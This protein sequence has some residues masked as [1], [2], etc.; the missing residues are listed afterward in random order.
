MKPTHVLSILALTF[1]LAEATPCGGQPSNLTTL[2]DPLGG[3]GYADGTGSAARFSL[4]SGMAVDSAGNVYVG[5]SENHAIRKITPGGVVSTLAGLAGFAGS[6]DGTGASARFASPLGVAVDSAG[7]VYV[8]DW[9][10]NTIRKITPDGAVSTLAGKAGSQGSGDGTVSMARLDEP[11]GVAVDGAGNVYVVEYNSGLNPTIRKITPSGVVSTLARL[12]AIGGSDSYRPYGVTVD[13]AGTVYVANGRNSTVQKITPAGVVSTLA[14]LAGKS[15][16]DDGTG[17]NARFSFPSGVAV[18]SAG[19][20]YVADAWNDTIRKI[21]PGG[22]VSTLAGL[23]ESSGSDDGPGSA[24]RFA[25]PSDV[26]VDSV[27]NVYVADSGNH[28]I[29]KITPEGAVSTLAGLAYQGHA[30]STYEPYTFT[31]L[32][33]YAGYGSADGTGNAARFTGPS[34]VAMD[35]AG[36][37]YVADKDNHT[38]RKVTSAGVVTTLAGLAGS[39]GSVDGTGITARFNQPQ[40]VAVDSVGNV[41]V[42]DE[43]NNTIRKVT[44]AGVVT[45]LAGLADAAGSADGTGGAARFYAPSGVAVD[46]AGNIYVADGG[47]STIRKVTPEGVVTTLA[48]RAEPGAPAR[49]VDGT[50]AAAHFSHPDGVAVDSAGNVYVADTLNYTIRKV[51]PAGVVTTL[52]GDPSIKFGMPEPGYADGTGRAA[53]FNYPTGIAVDAATNVYVADYNNNAIRKVT[54]AGVV[55]TLAGLAHPDGGSADGT[56]TRARFNRPHGV[57]VDSAGNVY[58]ADAG[59]S[60]I[61]KMT[62]PG[63]VTT[64]AG[65]AGGAGNADGTGITTR[66]NRPS[67]LAVDNVGNVYVADTDNGTIRKVTPAGTVTTLAGLAGSFGS[68]DG[69]GSGARFWGL[70]G[71]TVDASGNVYVADTDNS[72][73]RKVTP[74][75]VVTTLAGLAAQFDN[76]GNILAGGPGNADGTGSAA[77]FFNP[78]GLAVDNA[79]N[80]YVADTFNHTIRKMT[81]AGVVTTLAGLAA[82][83]DNDG[84]ILAGGPGNADGTGSA[85]RFSRPQGVAVDSAGNVYVAD[86]GNS[87]LFGPVSSTIRKVTPAGVVTTLAG[88]AGRSGSVDG[89]GITARF[90]QPQGV[91][92]DSAGNIYVTESIGTVRKVTPAGAVTTLAG[93]VDKFGNAD[94]TGSVARFSNPTGVAVDCAG[95][96]YVA[97]TYNN[98]IRKGYPALIILKSGF[99]GRKF[100]LNLT[101]QVGQS[102]ALETSTDLVKWLPAQ[103]ATFEIRQLTMTDPDASNFTRRFYRVSDYPIF[104]GE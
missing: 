77:R 41:Y 93:L 59:N 104:H 16:S 49:N 3:S 13:S 60:T 65:L 23:G 90:N 36:N 96:V 102:V 14:G 25:G 70:S 97:D 19:N 11:S 85:A 63:A 55:T 48:G 95:N 91:A 101:G 75:G 34:G 72:T 64:L 9:G 57:A 7:S 39:A 8:A 31:T 1:V 80:I 54:M 21:T 17:A 92:V 73:I 88:L 84:N 20:V 51:T 38:I 83:F 26:A 12:S 46:S 43:G 24:A 56:G 10:N 32:A 33:G 50:G 79:G 28:T 53:R 22:V 47:N 30:P 66:F 67:G 37:A 71:V 62:P 94:G 5:D 81:P 44:P 18:D 15:G 82:Q 35:S 86:T 58:V 99:D 89:T 100:V 42:A 6:D 40:G 68:A 61:R 29:R 4:P 103:S 78:R 98:T 2:P 74:E 69:T 27:G 45:T 87:P 52:A 76:D